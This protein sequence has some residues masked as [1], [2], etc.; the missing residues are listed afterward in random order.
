[1]KQINSNLSK[2]F[3]EREVINSIQCD[4]DEVG[5]KENKNGKGKKGGKKQK[6]ES[7]VS[8]LYEDVERI[9][10]EV[11]EAPTKEP[12]Q[13]TEATIK[14]RKRKN[15]LKAQRLSFEIPVLPKKSREIGSVDV[16]ALV[17]DLLGMGAGTVGGKR[18]LRKIKK[19]LI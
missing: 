7:A 17:E 12:I 9:E 19:S 1:M 2:E 5:K 4:D 13:V 15:A 6:V 8:Q 11:Q 14:P 3:S 16:D 10:T 18:K